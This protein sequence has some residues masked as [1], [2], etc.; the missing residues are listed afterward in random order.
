[1]DAIGGRLALVVADH[2]EQALRQAG[3]IGRK[4]KVEKL[5]AKCRQWLPKRI[6]N[7]HAYLCHG[8]IER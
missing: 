5:V 1:M 7:V 2:A 3:M 4:P 6:A 8:A